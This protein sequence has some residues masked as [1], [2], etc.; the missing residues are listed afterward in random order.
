VHGRGQ[1][2]GGRPILKDALPRWLAG[3]ACAGI[4]LAFA[5]ARPRDG[6]DGATYVQLR[7][8]RRDDGNARGGEPPY[9][10]G[11]GAT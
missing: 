9:R 5:P 4:V 6:G 1:H 10:P 2:S 7:R 11:S 3:G 8:A